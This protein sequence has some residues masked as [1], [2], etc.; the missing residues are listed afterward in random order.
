M[1]KNCLSLIRSVL[2]IRC[3]SYIWFSNVV[4]YMFSVHVINVRVKSSVIFPTS[5]I[6]IEPNAIQ[7]LEQ[8]HYTKW[9][10][11][12][13]KLYCSP[14][15]LNIGW[16][17][18]WSLSRCGSTFADS[19]CTTGALS[20]LSLLRYHE[21]WEFL[22]FILFMLE[23]NLML[24]KGLTIQNKTIQYEPIQWVAMWADISVN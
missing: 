2:M 15:G 21:W 12:M 4:G 11:F 8:S 5:Y 19:L 9:N 14:N 17:K 1:G 10:Q 23:C 7:T 20:S 24:E 18:I 3:T 22:D 6:K 13:R 16:A